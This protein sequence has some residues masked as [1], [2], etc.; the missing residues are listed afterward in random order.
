MKILQSIPKLACVAQLKHAI[1]AGVIVLQLVCILL[2]LTSAISYGLPCTY[3]PGDVNGVGGVN[4][5]DVVAAVIYFKG[6]PTPA[7]DCWPACNTDPNLWP[8]LPN[9]FFAAGDVNGNCAF[10]GIDITYFVRYLTG[11]VPILLH[12]QYCCTGC[13]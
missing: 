10:N 13:P 2:L 3:T 9:Q 1:G 6:G 12:C 4:G 8:N 5:I 11:Q 7:V